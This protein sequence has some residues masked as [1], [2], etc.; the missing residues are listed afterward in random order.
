MLHDKVDGPEGSVRALFSR[1]DAVL[2]LTLVVASLLLPPAV[3][4]GYG[5]LRSHFHKIQTVDRS[6]SPRPCAA[7]T[8]LIRSLCTIHPP[9]PRPQ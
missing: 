9:S 1:C 7:L 2:L 8:D 5:E 4:E 6:A 3:S